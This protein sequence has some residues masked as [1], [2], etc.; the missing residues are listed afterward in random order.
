MIFFWFLH[1]E[2]FEKMNIIEIIVNQNTTRLL[3]ESG[4]GGVLR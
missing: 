3:L 2:N 4:T 1:A